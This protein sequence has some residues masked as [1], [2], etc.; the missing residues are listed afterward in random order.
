[1]PRCGRRFERVCNKLLSSSHIG[2]LVLK[3]WSVMPVFLNRC[4]LRVINMHLLKLV[5][6]VGFSLGVTFSTTMAAP[7]ESGHQPLELW[8]GAAM[9]NVPVLIKYWLYFMTAVLALGLLFIW[10]HTFARLIIGGTLVMFLSLG[11]LAPQFG[12]PILAGLAALGHVVCWTPGLIYSL[13]TRPFLAGFTP[14]A[15]WSGVMTLVILISFVF[16]VPDALIYL[17]HVSGLKFLS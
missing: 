9:E 5:L 14:H 2:Y 13:K 16:D 7:Y 11:L 6:M 4:L 15:I 12:I 17:D 1:M 8:D 3:A 10:R